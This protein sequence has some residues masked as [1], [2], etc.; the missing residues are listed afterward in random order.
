MAPPPPVESLLPLSPVAFEI[1]L[2]LADGDAH[3][4]H[5]MQDVERRT[6]GAI[7]LHPGTLY[8][9][10]ARMLESG[11]IDEIGETGGRRVH[12]ARRA[13][14]LT[15]LGR[16]VLEREAARLEQQVRQARARRLLG[17]QER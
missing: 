5:I 9:A 4:Y 11:V 14:R 10:L 13:Y 16:S 3:G 1:L 8:R 17:K 15:R 6:D 12:A 2:T 7:V